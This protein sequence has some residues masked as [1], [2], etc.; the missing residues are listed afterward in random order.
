M[1]SQDQ[2][3]RGRDDALR[4]FF[5]RQSDYELGEDDA[6]YRARKTREADEAA[7]AM[8][9]IPGFATF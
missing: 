7:K 2:E 5:D 9:A 4:R 8:E 1:A 6:A 3:T